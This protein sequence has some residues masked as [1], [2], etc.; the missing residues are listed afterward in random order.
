MKSEE[1]TADFDVDGGCP[2]CGGTIAVRLRAGSGWG[3]CGHCHALQRKRVEFESD[4]IAI[5]QPPAAAA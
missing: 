4:Q 1:G 2:T 3:Y 5:I